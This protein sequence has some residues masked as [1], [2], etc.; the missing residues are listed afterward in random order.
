MT[1]K[2][3][4]EKG[5]VLWPFTKTGDNKYA[6]LST[7]F[8]AAS[9]IFGSNLTS[10]IAD[11]MDASFFDSIARVC[12]RSKEAPDYMHDL[13]NTFTGPISIIKAAAYLKAGC[14]CTSLDPGAAV[15]L[16]FMLL[17]GCLP[18]ALRFVKDCTIDTL[19]PDEGWNYTLLTEFLLYPYSVYK[20]N[21]ASIP[22]EYRELMKQLCMTTPPKKNRSN[23][24]TIYYFANM[25]LQKQKV[26]FLQNNDVD[27]Y[28]VVDHLEVPNTQQWFVKACSDPYKCLN[29]EEK[30]K[31][32]P[33]KVI[34]SIKK[35]FP[36]ALPDAFEYNTRSDD[37]ILALLLSLCSD[38]TD[39]V[40]NKSMGIRV[41]EVY[42]KYL[43]S[44]AI[45]THKERTVADRIFWLVLLSRDPEKLLKRM[46]TRYDIRA[47][48]IRMI[49]DGYTSPSV[50]KGVIKVIESAGCAFSLPPWPSII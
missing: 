6:W 10:H 9:N 25:L 21:F 27:S 11:N 7:A 41:V 16:Q 32:L 14:R 23:N 29:D 13:N 22:P 42:E 26:F 19:T 39:C 30:V 28:R 35:K 18:E 40:M 45:I 34:E 2:G 50:L 4:E 36:F 38:T 15:V 33:D 43:D 20:Y 44:H 8:A 1:T 31:V 46:I 12:K 47:R 49:N 17:S 37:E 5:P 48:V 24:N 3:K